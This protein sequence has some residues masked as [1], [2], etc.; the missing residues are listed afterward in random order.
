MALQWHPREHTG[1]FKLKH[2][3][4]DGN[5]LPD[6]VI[7][8]ALHRD[9]EEYF[10]PSMLV[11]VKKGNPIELEVILGNLLRVAKELGVN[12]PILNFLYSLLTVVQY[13]LREGQG[14]FTLPEERPVS[15]KFYH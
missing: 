5:E 2:F 7:N 8:T 6:D 4:Y 13:R 11:D 1:V 10:E 9:G 14:L 3:A 15:K 12:T